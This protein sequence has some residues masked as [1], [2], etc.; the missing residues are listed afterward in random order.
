MDKERLKLPKRLDTPAAIK[1]APDLLAVVG[2]PLVL[3][4]SKITFAG[5]LGLQ[6]L[7]SARL[8]WET[9]GLEFRLD[10]PSPALDEARRQLGLSTAELGYAVEPEAAP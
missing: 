9:D 6:V 3:D 2:A 1:L 7:A 8:Q 5:A 4:G 10:N